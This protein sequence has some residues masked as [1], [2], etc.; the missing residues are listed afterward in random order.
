MKITDPVG[1][2]TPFPPDD[3]PSPRKWPSKDGLWVDNQLCLKYCPKKKCDSFKKY[4]EFLQ[5][6]RVKNKPADSNPGIELGVEN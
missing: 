4:R 2:C 3:C 6:Q 1:G 5:E